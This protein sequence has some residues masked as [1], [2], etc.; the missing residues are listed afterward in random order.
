M[1]RIFAIDPSLPNQG[2]A[3]SLATTGRSKIGNRIHAT[4]VLARFPSRSPQPAA[5]A[6]P[7]PKLGLERLEKVAAVVG[8]LLG[9]AGFGWQVFDQF[10]SRSE[11]ITVGAGEMLAAPD[12][13]VSFPLSIINQGDRDIYVRSVRLRSTSGDVELPRILPD[14]VI[15]LES[16]N[17]GRFHSTALGVLPAIAL[18]QSRT[19]TV[20]VQTTRKTHR[21]P[22]RL[23]LSTALA[24][25]IPGSAARLDSTTERAVRSRLRVECTAGL[26]RDADGN[27]WA[28]GTATPGQRRACIEV[29]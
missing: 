10:Q 20:D 25:A 6:A 13:T 15:K 12:G 9:V 4:M 7:K 26:W 17:L 18:S 24:A 16:G 22:V 28:G 14:S 3:C 27:L 29:D 21:Y 23:E 1:S 11:I 8:V 2:R 19:V 5:H